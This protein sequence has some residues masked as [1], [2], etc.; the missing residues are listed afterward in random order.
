MGPIVPPCHRAP[1]ENRNR[2][3]PIAKNFEDAFSREGGV[4]ANE[5]NDSGGKQARGE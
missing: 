4:T 1:D 2:K 3:L 5:Q